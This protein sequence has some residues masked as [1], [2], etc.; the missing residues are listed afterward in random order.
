MTFVKIILEEI[1]DKE[2]DSFD[3]II[4]DNGNEFNDHYLFGNEGYRY[5]NATD[6]IDFRKNHYE[7]LGYKIGIKLYMSEEE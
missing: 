5:I 7:A 3:Y 6:E 4:T 1:Y 2:N